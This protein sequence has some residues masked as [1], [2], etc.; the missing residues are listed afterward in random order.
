M[1]LLVTKLSSTSG[2]ESLK[3]R[4]PHVSPSLCEGVMVVMVVR[5]EGKD[6]RVT[7]MLSS[8][9]SDKEE[10]RK[11]HALWPIKEW[12]SWCLIPWISFLLGTFS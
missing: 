12:M 3:T 7:P 10:K 6:P 5:W 8:M 1:Q 4:L 9:I 11:K 2:E